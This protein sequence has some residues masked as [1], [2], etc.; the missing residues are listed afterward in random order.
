[1]ILLPHLY[2]SQKESGDGELLFLFAG[3][4][5]R[6]LP[7]RRIQGIKTGVYA[8]LSPVAKRA[9]WIAD[10]LVD[11]FKLDY[12]NNDHLFAPMPWT[13]P[14]EMVTITPDILQKIQIASEKGA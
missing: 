5:N 4:I 8:S 14:G 12:A 3:Y 9:I 10:S 1:M 13:D 7:S 11:I 6:K 2:L